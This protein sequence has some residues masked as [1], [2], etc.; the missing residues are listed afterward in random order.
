MKT[1]YKYE[2][3]ECFLKSAYPPLFTRAGQGEVTP[4]RGLWFLH[5]TKWMK[6]L[7]G[8]YIP[9]DKNLLFTAFYINNQRK[10]KSINND[11]QCHC[12]LY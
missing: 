5:K 12:G 3:E 8:N 6:R 4:K 7:I 1:A 9:A 11:K 2:Y 10:D